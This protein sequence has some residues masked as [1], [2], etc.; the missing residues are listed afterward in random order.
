MAAAEIASNIL[1][2]AGA[3]FAFVAALGV[4][5][6]PDL[7]TRMHASSKA[8]TFGMGLLVLAVAIRHPS[9]ETWLKAVLIILF[10]VL[11]TPVATHLLV[12]VAY[13]LNVPRA[14]N[15]RYDELAEV[16]SNHDQNRGQT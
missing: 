13:R 2:I 15:S 7:Y 10:L 14:A 6:L 9:A 12:R 1:A 4:L 5:R 3:F 11:T 16:L 8:T